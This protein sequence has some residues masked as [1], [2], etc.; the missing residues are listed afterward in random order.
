M[1]NITDAF[2]E[3]VFDE[4]FYNENR[5]LINNYF[6]KAKLGQYYGIYQVHNN[7]DGTFTFNANG[8]WSMSN[9]L[10]WCLTPVNADA[11]ALFDE[12]FNALTKARETISFDYTDYNP[13]MVWYKHIHA[14]IAPRKTPNDKTSEYFDIVQIEEEDLPT[15]EETLLDDAVEPGIY[16][17]AN[18]RRTARIWH[19]IIINLTQFVNQDQHKQMYK[20]SDVKTKFDNYIN[21]NPQYNGAFLE[22]HY[23]DPDDLKYWYNTEFSKQFN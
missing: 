19:S 14:V 23:E 16:I 22:T 8:R 15:D 1:A 20:I 21:N 18:D 9:T 11:K 5:Q 3:F 6:T 17:N 13:A 7:G 10:S 2:G 12:F 4:D